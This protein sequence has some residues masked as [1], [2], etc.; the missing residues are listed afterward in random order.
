MLSAHAPLVWNGTQWALIVEVD[1]E[2]V[3]GPLQE[4]QNKL[5]LGGALCVLK[6]PRRRQRQTGNA[7]KTHYRNVSASYYDSR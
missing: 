2:M 1:R 4:L 3:D 5:L 7:H 6:A